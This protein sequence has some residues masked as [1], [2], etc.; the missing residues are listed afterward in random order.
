MMGQGMMMGQAGQ[1]MM[2]Q[3]MMSGGMMKC[4]MEVAGTTVRMEE[5]EGGAAM[6][7]STKSDVAELRRRVAAMA[8]M[9]G[10]HPDGCPMMKMMHQKAGEAPD[11]PPAAPS[12]HAS[13]HP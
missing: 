9:H 3:G 1:G 2:G 12:D 6:I 4:P 10:K 5:V 11:S 7:F 8:E 13:H